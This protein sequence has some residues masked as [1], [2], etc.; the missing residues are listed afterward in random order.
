MKGS[1]NSEGDIFVQV[2][3]AE[4]DDRDLSLVESNQ[5]TYIL[6]S[7]WSGAKRGL[8]TKT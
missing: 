5:M 7:H 2:G 6:A 3:A 1:E 4:G 8:E